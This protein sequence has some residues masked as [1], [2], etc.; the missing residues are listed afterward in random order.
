MIG[1]SHHLTAFGEVFAPL[2]ISVV[3]RAQRA[4]AISPTM[5]PSEKP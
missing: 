2:T 4:A 3:M 1:R 5:P